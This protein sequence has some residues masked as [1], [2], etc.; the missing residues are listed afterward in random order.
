MVVGMNSFHA[1]KILRSDGIID[2]RLS[3]L[4][5]GIAALDS[6]LSFELD[7]RVRA[8]VIYALDVLK[9]DPVRMVV[10]AGLNLSE[11]DMDSNDDKSASRPDND[12]LAWLVSCFTPGL[13]MSQS[14]KKRSF[15]DTA[16]CVRYAI[17]LFGR[18]AALP[19]PAWGDLD[20]SGPELGP[21]LLVDVRNLIPILKGGGLRFVDIG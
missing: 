19:V 17:R 4:D 1:I 11:D 6:I 21:A 20:P 7:Q 9:M 14:T 15:K 16:R 13:H 10:P 18:P 8:S 5:N 2:Y 3:P 12:V